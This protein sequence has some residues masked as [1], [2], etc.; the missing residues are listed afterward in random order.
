MNTLARNQR[1]QLAGW[2]DYQGLFSLS[3][4]LDSLFESPLGGLAEASG[5]LG[6]WSPRVNLHEDKDNVYV[7]A[8]LPGLKVSEIE[9]SIENGTLS[10]GGERKVEEKHR[11]AQAYRTERFVGK[12]QRLI[13]LPASVDATKVVAQ[14]KDGVLSVTLPKAEEARRK[15]IEVKVN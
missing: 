1:Q 2:P 7:T 10:I 3:N 9:L 12:F 5:F 4:A 6:V 14:Y 11:D 13:T 8:E 15:Q